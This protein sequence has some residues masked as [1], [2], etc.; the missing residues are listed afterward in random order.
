MKNEHTAQSEKQQSGHGLVFDSVTKRF[1][2]NVAVRDVSL[3]LAPGERVAVIGPSGAGK[4]T[5]LRLAAGTLRPNAG[6][7]TFNGSTVTGSAATLAYQG[8]TLVDR[9][10]VLSNVLTGQIGGLSWLRGFIEP[11]LPRYPEPA[12]ERLDAVGLVE[13]ADVPVKSL[14]AGERQRVAFARALMQDAEVVL[15]DEPTANLDPSS[16]QNIIDVL[17]AAI[18]GELLITVLHDVHIA[19]EHFERIVGVAGGRIKFDAPASAVA[20]EQLEALFAAGAS[21]PNTDAERT[22][23][24]KEGGAPVPRYV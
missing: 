20:D 5:L 19:L 3:S 24:K 1:G 9:R 13:R 22:G 16:R 7:V 8:E 2:E 23:A 18:D 12:L 15:A 11:L 17:D 10:T 4:T 14:S 6:T 21:T